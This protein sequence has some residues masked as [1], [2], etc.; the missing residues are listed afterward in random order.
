MEEEGKLLSGY[1][2]RK[3]R[4]EQVGRMADAGV[5][6]IA[7][8]DC[9]WGSYPFG[10]L[11]YELDCMVQGGLTPMQAILSATSHAAEALGIGD[12]GG[13]AGAGQ[14]GGPAGGGG[15]SVGGD[16]GPDEGAGGVQGR[17]AGGGVAIAEGVRGGFSE[18][19]R[20]QAATSCRWAGEW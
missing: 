15:G 4:V 1:E 16:S 7:G 18:G 6:L 12:R 17:G 8:S 10:Q 19:G 9:G 13:G 20:G 14:S 5:R 11:H 2:H 3:T